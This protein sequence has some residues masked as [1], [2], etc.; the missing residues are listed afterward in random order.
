LS[1]VLIR[2]ASILVGLFL[3]LGLVELDLRTFPQHLPGWYLNTLPRGGYDL[4]HPGVLGA[5]PIDGVPVPI[6]SQPAQRRE[7]F[8]VPQ[9]LVDLGLVSADQSPDP[10]NYLEVQ[11]GWDELGFPNP[12]P[13]SKT[14]VLFIGDSFALATGTL[15]PAGLQERL[16][17]E[18]GLKVGNL[19]V[20]GLCPSRESYLLTRVG[21]EREPR[22]V[23]WFYFGG[24]DIEEEAELVNAIQKGVETY[25]GGRG[26]YPTLL[27]LDLARKSLAQPTAR[28]NSDTKSGFI[29]Q[30]REGPLPVW[31]HPDYLG[32]LNQD[33]STL[34]DSAG[35]SSTC[36]TIEEAADELEKRGIALLLVYVPSKP[37]VYLH[38]VDPDPGLFKRSIS[39]DSDSAGQE[40]ADLLEQALENSRNQEM[41]VAEFAQR[42]GIDFLSLSPSYHRLADGGEMGFL[43]ADTHWN[44]I[45]QGLALAP[46]E[47]WLDEKGL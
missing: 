2:A 37:E 1:K 39:V 41:L 43:C 20:A 7:D 8:S 14:D 5:T 45:G 36:E 46:I 23:I 42:R 25:P 19:G 35:W 3:A 10:K 13:W 30:S 38:H 11:F 22:A 9:D 4:F 26:A 27:S 28:Q 29:F 15:K 6:F 18:T 17:Q 44:E 33:T 32:R 40:D 31:F 34:R 21:L 12:E 47:G 24:N 16:A